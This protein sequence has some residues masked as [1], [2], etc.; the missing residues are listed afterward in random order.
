M[1]RLLSVMPA[2]VKAP[3]LAKVKRQSGGPLP[4]TKKARHRWRAL[5]S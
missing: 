3:A 4:D 1:M 5:I 2:P